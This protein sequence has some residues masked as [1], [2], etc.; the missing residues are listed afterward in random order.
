[1]KSKQLNFFITPEDRDSI[2]I[3]L[4][5]NNCYILVDKGNA[6]SNE[7]PK[8]EEGIFQVYLTKKEF[9]KNIRTLVTDNGVEYIDNM[10]SPVLQFNLGGFY[11]Y[12]NNLL[13]RGRFY[14]IAGYYN[15]N[16]N[17]VDKS[18]DFVNWSN[19][20][21]KSFRKEFL[22]KYTEESTFLYSESAITWIK[23]NN[24]VL[25]NGGQQ[26]KANL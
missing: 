3:F 13:Q 24:A 1:M 11:P 26:W 14:F 2:N 23:T 8:L 22:K 15:N 17:F 5:K 4:S 18:S 20:I 7:L 6:S 16:E 9:I 12:N 25:V 10:I 19:T 21:I